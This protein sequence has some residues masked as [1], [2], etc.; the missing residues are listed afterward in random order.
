MRLNDKFE[1]DGTNKYQLKLKSAAALSAGM[2]TMTV[3]AN[4][5]DGALYTFANKK[6]TYTITVT[7]SADIAAA[8]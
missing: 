8:P 4:V 7:A 3:T 5:A 2:Y 1:F 6:A